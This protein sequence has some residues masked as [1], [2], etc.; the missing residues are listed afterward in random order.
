M[1]INRGFLGWGVF[2]VLVGAVPL[3]VRAGYVTEDQIPNVVSLWPLILIGIGVGILLARTQYGFLGGLVVAAT[4]GLMVGGLLATGVDGL[5][6]GACGPGGATAAFPTRDGPLTATSASI[7]LDLNCGNVTVGV[8]PGSAWRI[9]GQDRDGIGPNIN[10]DNDSLS[11]RSRDGHNGF[12]DALDDRE[13][14]RVSL[15]DSVLLDLN[16]NLNAGSSNVDLGTAAIEALELDLNAG[17]ATLNLA[18]VRELGDLSIGLNAGS[19]AL[20]LPSLALSGSIEANAGSVDLCV[21]PG[22][23]L[24][25]NTTES[26]V[27]SYNF[28]DRGLVKQGSTWETP[29]FDSAD[30]RIE[31][32]TRANAG[33]FSLNPEDGCGG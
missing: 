31:L 30:V 4:F 24:R 28:G 2:L 7:D 27:A 15:P 21:S 10:A 11:V 26:I 16:M 8:Q 20:T 18:S 32:D 5:G 3:A 29:G 13:T 12:F 22:V 14:W 6:A 19:L 9:E 23:A 25:L 17:S 33:S 1:R